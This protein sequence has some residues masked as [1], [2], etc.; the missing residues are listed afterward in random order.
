M[1]T[2]HCMT[3]A[4]DGLVYVCNRQGARI[5]VYDKQGNF[6][7]NIEVLWTP[8]TTPP[9]GKPKESGGSAVALAFS[10]DSTQKLMYV[11]NQNN[12]EI[13]IMDRQTGKLLS[14]FGRAGHFPGQFD[15]PHSIAVDSKGNVYVAETRGKR[16]QKFK[17]VGQ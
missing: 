4:N 11:I 10:P 7:K 13:E 14:S 9:D 3:V 16:V 6:I 8:Y 1:Q 17:I 12:V 5:Q 2:V 15:S